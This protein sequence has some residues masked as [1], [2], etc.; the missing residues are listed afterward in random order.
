M[1]LNAIHDNDDISPFDQ[2]CPPPRQ[3]EQ[4]VASSNSTRKKTT[5]SPTKR[6]AKAKKE[7]S[8]EHSLFGDFF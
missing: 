5:N 7:M 1:I 8:A 4:E 6:K 2:P 3:Q